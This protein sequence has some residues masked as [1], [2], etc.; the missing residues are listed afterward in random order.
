[1]AVLQASNARSISGPGREFP[2]TGLQLRRERSRRS[3]RPGPPKPAPKMPAMHKTRDACDP[4]PEY[5]DSRNR[6][7]PRRL[8]RSASA[9][10]ISA[11]PL[12]RSRGLEVPT[13]DQ[14]PRSAMPNFT[15]RDSCSGCTRTD[16]G[17]RRTIHRLPYHSWRAD[18]RFH[19]DCASACRS[20]MSSLRSRRQ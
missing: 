13:L 18:K 5:R 2:A 14:T 6:Q 12:R 10:K 17:S 4:E 9:G 19:Q 16:R 8:R 7:R 20:A 15:T 11:L 1:M 3:R